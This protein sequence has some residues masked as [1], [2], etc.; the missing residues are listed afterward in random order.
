M[1]DIPYR[2]E[3]TH[4]AAGVAAG[5]GHLTDGEESGDTVSVAGRVMLLRRIGREQPDYESEMEGEAS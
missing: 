3:V 5:W 1:S 4:P 2:Y